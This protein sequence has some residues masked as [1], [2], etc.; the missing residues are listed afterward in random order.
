MSDLTLS[1]SSVL[2]LHIRITDDHSQSASALKKMGIKVWQPYLNEEKIETN[3]LGGYKIISMP[4]P[5]DGTPN[6]AFLIECDGEKLLYATD[7]EYLPYSMKKREI[8][9]LL[10]ECNYIDTIIDETEQ[11]YNHVLQ[12]HCELQTTLGIVKTN[13]TQN[14]RTVILCHL[15][16]DNSNREL[17]LSEVEKIAGCK[18]AIAEKGLSLELGLPFE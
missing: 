16:G 12:G 11:K 18:V 5:H 1:G 4:V 2:S 17:M 6:R 7:I 3:Y 13:K 15:S 10:V 8:D 14:L 9:T